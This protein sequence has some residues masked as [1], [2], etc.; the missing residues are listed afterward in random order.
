MKTRKILEFYQNFKEAERIEQDL[1][2]RQQEAADH[3]AAMGKDET[4]LNGQGA[5]TRSFK[6]SRPINVKFHE[7]G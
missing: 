7:K 3:A 2:R 1:Q 6:L 4:M 5:K